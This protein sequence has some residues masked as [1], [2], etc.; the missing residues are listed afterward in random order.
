MTS[1]LAARNARAASP[2]PLGTSV[3]SSTVPAGWSASSSCTYLD[4]AFIQFAGFTFGKTQSFFEFLGPSYSYMSQWLSIDTGGS[5]PAVFAYT[6]QFGNGLSATISAE[7]GT[8][9]RAPI[10][11][12]PTFGAGAGASGLFPSGGSNPSSHRG[13]Q[14]PD[15]VGNLRVDQAWGSAQIM[16][17]LHPLA[18]NYYQVGIGDSVVAPVTSPYRLRGHRGREP[19]SRHRRHH[20]HRQQHSA[21]IPIPNGAGRLAAASP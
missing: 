10:V 14:I 5:G 9:H 17:A 4:R 6:M 21:L 19:S 20:R 8:Y 15:I 12:V 18:A 3:S 7:D 13:H 2:V 16:G 1:R 11:A